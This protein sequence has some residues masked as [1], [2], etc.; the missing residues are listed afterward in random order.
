M[1]RQVGILG[2]AALLFGLE[3]RKLV[4]DLRLALLA[5]FHGALQSLL[6][7]S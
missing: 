5:D 3:L 1:P 7:G 6:D 2:S 4:G